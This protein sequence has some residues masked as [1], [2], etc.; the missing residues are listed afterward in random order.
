[1]SKAER[2]AEA[3]MEDILASIRKIISDDPVG[4]GPSLPLPPAARP[5]PSA[6]AS[7]IISGLA[8][9]PGALSGTQSAIKPEVP[10]S[11]AS[12]MSARQALDPATVGGSE[13]AP[14]KYE[15]AS[16]SHAPRP[17]Q[18]TST[19]LRSKPAT[20]DL[21][22]EGV[23][24]ILRLAD[25]PGSGQ[26]M[27]RQRL[28]APAAGDA[29]PPSWLF[30]SLSATADTPR[31]REGSAAPR[32]PADEIA[33]AFLAS[34]PGADT[35]VAATGIGPS[36]RF[37]GDFGAFVP[38]RADAH[39]RSRHF[40]FAD[41]PDSDGTAPGGSDQRLTT[42]A[43]LS[44]L[45]AE[46]RLGPGT[47]DN[48]GL[49]SQDLSFAAA[50]AEAVETEIARA[51]MTAQA[52]LASSVLAS[53]SGA[54]TPADYSRLVTARELQAEIDTRSAPLID[55]FRTQGPLADAARAASKAPERG[56]RSALASALPA[57]TTSGLS[58]AETV[59]PAPDP[60]LIER[61][62]AA[63][64]S[65]FSTADERPATNAPVARAAAPASMPPPVAPHPV[66]TVAEKLAFDTPPD[67]TSR[68]GHAAASAQSSLQVPGLAAARETP[69][70]AAVAAN[71]SSARAATAGHAA[72][73]PR[74]AVLTASGT[75]A[76]ARTL[77]DTV[78]EMLRPMLRKWLD[79]NMPRI[80]EQ[81]M[82]V[83]L[84]EAAGAPVEK[85][86][87]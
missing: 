56:T 65:V 34:L 54:E 57:E 20:P 27:P 84:A 58:K 45:E 72:G 55:T 19:A 42:S 61:A 29:G 25:E 16:A 11:P 48:L 50:R 76:G 22:L 81:A 10:G 70:G 26:D 43:V 53:R 73:P 39:A 44:G 59:F 83:E 15:G 18:P 12:G 32:S 66:R 7:P 4:A 40:D 1:M 63:A 79:D 47:P 82:R 46:L 78:A 17:G 71:P 60:P 68:N 80:V 62:L 69:Q 51:A 67:S 35:L 2:A 21:N 38:R 5:S 13:T 23:D 33:G 24:D 31:S 87:G 28:V 75:A 9:A 77:E 49:R 85:P 74:P 8:R 30:P 52:A 64:R 41:R 37:A 14:P 86:S 36:G 3:S 6:T